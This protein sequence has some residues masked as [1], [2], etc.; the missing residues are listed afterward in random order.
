MKTILY[1]ITIFLIIQSCNNSNLDTD[2][3]PIVRVYDKY[4]Y[5][6]DLAELFSENLTEQ[7]SILI[8]ENIVDNWINKQLMMQKA[9]EN[10]SEEQDEIEKQVEDYKT[11]L[12]IF[13][14]QQNFIN[15]NLDTVI[16]LEQLQECYLQFSQDFKLDFEAIKGL[17]IKIS[18]DVPN[19]YK[20]RNWYRS[21]DEKKSRKLDSFCN[22]NAETY[23][24]FD[25]DWINFNKLIKE[26]PFH[27][28]DN[29]MFLKYNKSYET[30]DSLFCYFLNI[31]DY[32][33]KNDTAPLIFVKNKLKK[34]IINKRKL[35]I[36]RE[37]EKNI[38]QDALNSK[39]ILIY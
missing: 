32:K 5:L 30:R 4:L 39:K 36:I 21:D 28:S 23:N 14:Y 29:E 6:E 9:D 11:S 16:S 2:K 1:I 35:Q 8:Y 33:L 19:L 13:K 12:L 24:D 27:F 7:D 15:Q 20:I 31:A 22:K 25:N 3:K 34:I 10:L 18:K 38:Y 17:F 37:L 26:I